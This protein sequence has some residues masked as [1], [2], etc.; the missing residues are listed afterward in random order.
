M[1]ARCDARRWRPYGGCRVRQ[2]RRQVAGVGNVHGISKGRPMMLRPHALRWSARLSAGALVVMAAG[3]GTQA[4]ASAASASR[5]PAIGEAASAPSGT[6]AAGGAT[7]KA[8]GHAADPFSPAFHHHYRHGVVPTRNA[9]RQMRAWAAQHPAL[10]QRTRPAAQ[11]APPDN[12]LVYGGG[13][14]GIGVTT[15]HEQVYLV[16]YGSQWGRIGRDGN[17]DTT[18]SG[19]TSKEA[20]YLQELLK[21]LGTGGE[22]WSG[23]M[24][25][26]CDDATLHAEACPANAHQT[27]YPAGGVLAGVWVDE[28]AA[29]PGT[30]TAKQLGAEAVKAAGHF[31]NTTPG[32]NRDAQYVILSPKGTHPDGFNTVTGQFCAWHDWNGDVGAASSY[33]D[34]AFTNM[35]YVTDAGLSCGKDFVNPTTGALDG[36]SIVEG[37]EYAETITDQNPLG[38]W[39]VPFANQNFSTYENA[40]MCAWD[41]PQ[42]GDPNAKNLTLATGTFAMQPT[43]ANDFNGGAG[44][45]EFTHAIVTNANTVTVTNPGSQSSAAGSAIASLPIA[46]S[47]SD[48]GQTLTYRATRLPTGLSINS[49]TGV[50]SGT[51]T[52][53]GTY[54]ATVVATDT[55]GAAGWAI[56]TWR[57]NGQ[58]LGNPG[59]ESGT[60][61]PW[62]STSGVLMKASSTAPA[63]SGVWLARLDGRGTTHTDTLAQT[64]KIT[65]ANSSASFSF[66][67]EIRSNDPT[68]KAYDTLKVQVLN[69]SGTVLKTLATYSNRSTLGSYRQHSFSLNSYLGQTITLKFT[70]KETLLHHNT[71][72]FV[73]DTAL[74]AS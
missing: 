54:S 29:S 50:I 27:A 45:C 51:P 14:D 57:I 67:L 23:V 10:A 9:S 8:T 1:I 42:P 32:S 59:L 38:G 63:H 2:R 17:G 16:F 34:I 74:N 72:F 70:G 30:A 73:D 68:T 20:P 71:S 46:A 43:W 37:H 56:F 62:K 24:T 26:Y 3:A 40:D 18:L 6:G 55:T 15:G 19:D 7:G 21:G 4:M 64:V 31:G 52:A 11:Q 53:T 39:A 12:N 61:A 28:A 25:Q 44:G 65:N 47:D 69:S 66:W 22:Q 60:I 13:V 33:G 58:L 48:S 41:P 35:P 5:I 36:V 49:S